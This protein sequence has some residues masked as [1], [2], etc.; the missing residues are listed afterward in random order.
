MK[1]MKIITTNAIAEA[2]ILDPES[3][4]ESVVDVCSC[5][6]EES[7]EVVVDDIVVVVVDVDIVVG[8]SHSSHSLQG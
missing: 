6:V 2:E 5:S 3:L 8:S 1:A 4:I 7:V